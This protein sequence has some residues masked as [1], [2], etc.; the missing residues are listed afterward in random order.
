[1]S[2]DLIKVGNHLGSNHIKFRNQ[3]ELLDLGEDFDAVDELVA[4]VGHFDEVLGG[5]VHHGF[6]LYNML[7]VRY[8]WIC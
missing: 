8:K 2:I 7:M 5:I 4:Q 1:M 3:E 6:L